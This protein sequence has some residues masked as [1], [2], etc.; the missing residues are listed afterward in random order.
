MTNLSNT[1]NI[2][3]VNKLNYYAVYTHRIQNLYQTN[4]LFELMPEKHNLKF[5]G[6]KFFNMDSGHGHCPRDVIT[7]EKYVI[8]PRSRNVKNTVVHDK[9]LSI[10]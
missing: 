1:E 2:N 3:T 9:Y 10:K 7:E 5:R 8:S 6:W 4:L